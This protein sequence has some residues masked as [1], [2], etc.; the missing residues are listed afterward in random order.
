[1]KFAL[2]KTT[3]M[4]LIFNAIGIAVWLCVA[5][6][7]WPNH[8]IEGCSPDGPDGLALIA[9][10]IPFSC[11]VFIVNTTAI[12]AVGFN[13]DQRHN[14]LLLLAIVATTIIWIGAAAFDYHM[15]T[16]PVTEECL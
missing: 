7:V 3:V 14:P 12:V 5:S 13:V 10:V 2:R 1:M 9:I 11:V 16:R 4:W 6:I 8:G 15:T